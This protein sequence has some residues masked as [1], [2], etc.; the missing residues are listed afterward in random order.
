VNVGVPLEGAKVAVKPAG[1]VVAKATFDENA[2]IAVTV[3]VAV[4]GVF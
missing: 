1:V 3:T 4:V 2:P